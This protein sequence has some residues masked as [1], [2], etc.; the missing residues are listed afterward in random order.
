MSSKDFDLISSMDPNFV[1]I[2][3]PIEVVK[4]SWGY[5]LQATE[6]I[7]K[8]EI[9]LYVRGPYM[10][11]KYCP[12]NEKT[13]FIWCGIEGY[14]ISPKSQGM[15]LNHACYPTCKIFDQWDVR[16]IRDVKKGEPITI[17]YNE[18]F[19]DSD[20]TVYWDPT[21]TFQCQCGHPKCKG[22]INSYVYY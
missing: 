13:Y 21:W 8:D 20:L 17:R 12:E 11:Y 3:F 19:V 2:G 4:L 15:Y 10:N 14:G 9:V 18:A 7:P 6:D 5:G 16:T 1:C 22:L